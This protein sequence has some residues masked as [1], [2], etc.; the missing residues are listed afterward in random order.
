MIVVALI[1]VAAAVLAAV[2]IAVRR[3]EP[4]LLDHD[5]PQPHDALFVPAAEERVPVEHE[6]ATEG[7][8]P[9]EA[10]RRT[11]HLDGDPFTA[12]LGDID[13]D[14]APEFAAMVRRTGIDLGWQTS[15]FTDWWLRMDTDA[16][17]V[18][19]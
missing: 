14:G 18:P 1:V 2:V 8:S 15:S 17:T 11:W 7:W 5:E 9:A 6:G 16:E 13:L 4:V 19:A 12:D 10:V 3:P